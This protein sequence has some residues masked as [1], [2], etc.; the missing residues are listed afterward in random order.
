M[1]VSKVSQ[2]GKEILALAFI[3]HVVLAEH[4]MRGRSVR[5]Y[6]SVDCAIPAVK[7]PVWN[8]MLKPAPGQE[9]PTANL[10]GELLN[11]MITASLLQT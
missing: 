7:N 3:Q 9:I 4:E 8:L 6:H 2:L 1:E 5:A 10:L 11:Q